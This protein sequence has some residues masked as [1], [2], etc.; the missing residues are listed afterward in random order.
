MHIRLMSNPEGKNIETIEVD[1]PRLKAETVVDLSTSCN[2]GVAVAKLIGWMKGSIFQ[3]VAVAN[4]KDKDKIYIEELSRFEKEN[5]LQE[6]LSFRR[7]CA[8]QALAARTDATPEELQE[9]KDAISNIDALIH[10]AFIYT[11][12]IEEELAKGHNSEILIDLKKSEQTG[13]THITLRSLDRWAKKKYGISI[14]DDQEQHIS[15]EGSRA[16]PSMQEKEEDLDS[17]EGSPG[18]REKNILVTLAFIVEEFA[19]TAPRYGK[20]KKP[21]ISVIARHIAELAARAN[22]GEPMVGQGYES[23]RKHISQALDIKKSNLP[24]R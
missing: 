17:N 6:M 24:Q 11:T 22:G 20:G 4:P 13:V 12:D 18:V 8:S 1:L 23:I 19:E 21:N 14:L 9:I 7:D 16:Q 3:E 5:Y 15:S 2:K 10:K